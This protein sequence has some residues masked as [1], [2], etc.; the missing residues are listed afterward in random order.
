MRLAILGIILIT[1][2]SCASNDE[3]LPTVTGQWSLDQVQLYNEENLSGTT[4]HE[5]GDVIY[6]FDDAGMN[7]Q[8]IIE[9]DGQ[10]EW[11][12]YILHH[13]SQEIE[14]DNGK[15]FQIDLLLDTVL[16]LS[17]HYEPYQSIYSFSRLDIN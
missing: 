16:I 13:E 8:L 12:H 17:D 6:W 7:A 4:E 14:L 1:L 10:S 9:E 5:K 15:R 11:H 2:M 3:L